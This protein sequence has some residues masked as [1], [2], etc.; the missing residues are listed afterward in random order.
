MLAAMHCATDAATPT[1]PRLPERVQRF[2]RHAVLHCTGTPNGLPLS[3]PEAPARGGL[4]ETPTNVLDV[5]HGRLGYFR[6]AEMRNAYNWR[7]PHIGYHFVIDL[8]GTVWT[9]RHLEETGMGGVPD[10]SVDICLVGGGGDGGGDVGRN[11]AD[12]TARF[13]AA[14]WDALGLL[15]V[16][17][18]TLLGLPLAAPVTRHERGVCGH[19]DK[20]APAGLPQRPCP[21]FDVGAYLDRGLQPLSTHQIPAAR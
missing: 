9:G 5:W 15:L 12:E 10:A 18:S 20:P 21:G 19:R 1:L 11:P 6:T 16:A 4:G 8:D 3:R 2:V 14:Q 17:L 13:T 7:L